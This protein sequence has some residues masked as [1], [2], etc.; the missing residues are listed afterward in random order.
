MQFAMQGPTGEGAGLLKFC[1]GILDEHGAAGLVL[2]V[3][4]I[5]FWRLIWKVWNAAMKSKDDEI[6]RLVE[7]RNKYQ[8]LVFENLLTSK[9]L[10]VEQGK[11]AGGPPSKPS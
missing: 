11:K 4:A 9:V 1:Q 3:L 10:R 7:E 6:S 5:L 8:A 2:V